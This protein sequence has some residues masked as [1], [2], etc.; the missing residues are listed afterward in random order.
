MGNLLTDCLRSVQTLTGTD[1][2]KLPICPRWRG[3]AV[4]REHNGGMTYTLVCGRARLQN[5]SRKKPRRDEIPASVPFRLLLHLDV[6]AMRM[7]SEAVRQQRVR[8]AT[9]FAISI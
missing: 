2:V 7:L 5:A 3:G 8:R 1:T 9:Y 6:D 4:W